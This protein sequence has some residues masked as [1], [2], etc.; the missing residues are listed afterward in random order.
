MQCHNMKT[1]LMQKLTVVLEDQAATPEQLPGAGVCVGA[2][3]V[4]LVE[5]EGVLVVRVDVGAGIEPPASAFLI[6]ISK[7]LLPNENV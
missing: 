4:D 5:V 3:E 2:V 6:P 7:R 1:N